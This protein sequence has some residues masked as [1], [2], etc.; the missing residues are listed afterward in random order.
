ME[1]PFNEWSP[2]QKMVE[3][4]HLSKIIIQLLVEIM[5]EKN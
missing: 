2:P 1:T 5:I 3:C 4:D